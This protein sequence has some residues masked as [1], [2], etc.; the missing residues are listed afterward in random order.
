MECV[1][2][3]SYY[4]L[5]GLILSCFLLA[6]QCLW[7]VLQTC[8]KACMHHWRGSSAAGWPA[9]HHQCCRLAAYRAEVHPEQ[10]GGVGR[11][12][13]EGVSGQSWNRPGRGWNRGRLPPLNPIPLCQACDLAGADSR[14][15]IKQ[16]GAFLGVRGRISHSPAETS[17][18][19]LS[20]TV[21]HN[22]TSKKAILRL[23]AL[24]PDRADEQHLAV[25]KCFLSAKRIS[26]LCDG[27]IHWKYTCNLLSTWKSQKKIV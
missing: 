1:N 27:K 3:V 24:S 7:W 14:S 20:S 2:N 16:D 19:L 6:L 22:G 4:K 12:E 13:G 18:L 9:P 23:G 10:R 25:K 17:S 11:G 26:S 5:N 21:D 8:Q 15:T